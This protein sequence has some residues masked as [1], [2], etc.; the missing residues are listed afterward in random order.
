MKAA[1]AVAV[2]IVLLV[3]AFLF[4][5]P[6]GYLVVN[7]PEKSDA[8]VVLAG[9]AADARYWRG[10]ELLRAG[11]AQ[12]VLVDATMGIT[13]G[14]SYADLAAEFVARTAGQEASQV[15]VCPVAGDSTKDEA[16][17]VNSCLQRLEPPPRSVIVATDDYHTRRALSIFRKELPQYRWTAAA[18]HNTF[19][20]GQPWWK[21]RE[22]AKTFLM[23]WQKLLWWE[24]IDRW[25]K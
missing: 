23:E 16:Q 25:R 13:Y 22:W 15:S 18:A 7:S 19:F 11:Y 4:L 9:D 6:G 10:L 14:H 20:F 3:G 21:N 12:H 5:N 24:L 2:V 1:I 8:I 17:Q